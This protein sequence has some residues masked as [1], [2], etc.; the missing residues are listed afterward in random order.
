MTIPS[1]PRKAGPLLGTG[2]QTAWPFTFKV[3]AE[4][5]IAVA[6]ADSLGVETAL[7]LN[8]DYT[9]ALN[10]NQDT[11]PGGTIT[12]PVSGSP[13]A[14]GSALTVVGDLDYDQ[15][16]DIPN[17]GNF[18]PV[19]LENELDRLTMQIQQLREIT[20]R[21]FLSP[22]T[23]DASGQL[24]AP[25]ANTLIGWDTT[26][27]TLQNVPLSSIS[28]VATYG[29][30]ANDLFVGDGVT[31]SFTLTSDPFVLANMT[32]VVD[33]LTLTA[34]T[35]FTLLAGALV[36]AVAPSNGAEI[37]ARY[38][39]AMDVGVVS[40]S[41]IS[42][43]TATGQ[44][45]IT[46][47]NAAAARAAIDTAKSGA[48][49]DITSVGAITGVT[50]TLGDN[51]AKLAT[52]AFVAANAAVQVPT[53]QTVLSGPVDSNGFAAFG[54]STG[55]TTVTASGTLIATAANGLTNR[56]GT[57]VNPSWTGLTA[58]AYLYLDI[59]S[60]GTCTTGST[61]VLPTYRWGGADV[62]TTNQ[63]TFNIQEMTGKVG[64]GATAAQTYRVFVGEVVASG[65][66]SAITW[67]QM[68][69]R[70]VAPVGTNP[71]NSNTAVSLNHN[72]GNSL[73]TVRHQWIC[74]SAEAGYS[75]GDPVDSIMNGS[76]V[77]ILDG[78]WGR[79]T[80]GYIANMG[81]TNIC[82]K[83]T[84]TLTTMT[85]A[86]WDYRPIVTRAF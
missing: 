29:A 67:H 81:I 82:H 59:A 73:V 79:L 8:V 41:S 5:D 84:S 35:D 64:N 71:N 1:T 26:G 15:P 58:S 69:G 57:I 78:T 65:T 12:Y 32:A 51:S 10:A 46:A 63:F 85:L 44:D 4:S 2:V 17:G 30:F 37:V 43:S 86:K 24:P 70:Y 27:T 66:V 49:S 33:G 54:G 16:M 75:V 6:I 3:F 53:R 38:G 23:S 19:A 50:A 80:V 40:S 7:A 83:S 42:D 18:S 48:N 36:F 34:G 31:A 9:V 74:N 76:G 28:T 52:T 61:T 72:I 55:S 56:V 21:A 77:P 47:A 62:V 22:I 11:S 20:S 45:L 68:N 14:V 13:L 60:D 25:A 39:Q